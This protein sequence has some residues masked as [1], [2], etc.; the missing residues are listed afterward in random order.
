MN[1]DFP[2]LG[3]SSKDAG[4]VD[5]FGFLKSQLPSESAGRVGTLSLPPG[6]PLP[7]AH[8]ASAAFQEHMS[9]SKP[10][11]PA[12]IMPPGLSANVSRVGTP[13]KQN[14]TSESRAMTPEMHSRNASTSARVQDASQISFG[15]PVAKSAN[16]TR[17]HA[18]GDL[19]LV[20]DEKDPLSQVDQ[21][22]RISTK[23]SPASVSVPL[24]SQEAA[25]TKS[26]RGFSGTFASAAG[27][28]SAIGSRPHT[29]LTTAP[30][31]PESSAA[32]QPRILRVVETPKPAPPTLVGTAPSVAASTTTA[33]KS[34]SRRQSMSSNSRPDTPGD[35]GSEADFYPSTSASRANS[36]LGSSRIGSAPVRSITKSQAKKERRQKAKEAEA[37]K[38]ETVPVPQELVQAPIMG[39]KRKTKKA[40]STP[41]DSADGF[42]ASVAETAS[43][44][45]TSVEPPKKVE[46][47]PEPPK[48]VKEKEQPVPEI[49]PARTEAP[50]AP[51][52]PHVEEA[53]HSHNTVQQANKDAEESG[54]SIKDILME[55]TKPLHEILAQMH[56]CGS[57]DLNKSLLF[58]PVGLGQRTDMKCT[59]DDYDQL[60]QPL[61]L[62]DEHRKAL[63][64]GE[65]VH[66]GNGQLKNRCLITPRGSVLR[67]L[68]PEEEARYLQLEKQRNGF[69]DPFVVGDDSSNINGGLEALFATPEKYN[70]RWVDEPARQGATSP[71]TALTAALG[72]AENV[73]PP[74]VLSA[75]EAD[76]TRNHDWAIAHSAELLQT[77]TDAVRS[78]AAATAKQILGTAGIPC[79]NPSLEDVSAMTNEELKELS[80]RSQKDLESTRKELDLLDKKFAA[81]LR[82]NKKVQQQALSMVDAPN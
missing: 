68:E 15:S 80:G 53:W 46:P 39:R 62:T 41:T 50:P 14:Q 32:R 79:A 25:S 30:G 75:M 78:F 21:S 31:I 59:A 81:L 27:S 67:H 47:K 44:I 51:P 61:E 28:T 82:R 16:K 56:R 73:V 26:E 2:P 19:R 54:R 18:K 9:S 22:P 76:S 40:T 65:P 52:K 37:K 66:I 29:P 34:R 35:Y 64:R 36:P 4:P 71:T 38:V 48:K 10:A 5:P 24:A 17:L 6:L 23:G 12:P 13:A 1:D 8:P 49:K 77:T 69:T 58:N 42:S 72:A 60:K 33:D 63:R 74:N 57:L 70:I 3:G 45:K 7:H 43:P 55:R 20:T 11:S